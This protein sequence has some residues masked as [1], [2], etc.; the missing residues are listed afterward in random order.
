MRR[1]G[2]GQ[3]TVLWLEPSRGFAA[4]VY[5][6]LAMALLGVLGA[7]TLDP[8]GSVSRTLAR[9]GPLPDLVHNSLALAVALGLRCLLAMTAVVDGRRWRTTR[10][11][12]AQFGS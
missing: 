11:S 10:D 2:M 7:L 9:V 6:V 12:A 5:G 3:R 1:A 8:R 4:V